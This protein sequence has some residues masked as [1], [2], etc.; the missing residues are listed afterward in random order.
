MRDFSS[1]DIHRMGMNVV[2]NIFSDSFTQVVYSGFPLFGCYFILS[3]TNDNRGSTFFSDPE[4]MFKSCVFCQIIRLI[5]FIKNRI[6]RYL[7]KH[8][9]F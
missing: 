4:A 5:H 9:P 3:A 1:I 8:F 2:S 7:K 6:R